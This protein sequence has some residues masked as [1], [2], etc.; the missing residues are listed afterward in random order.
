MRKFLLSLIFL[1]ISVSSQSQIVI[2]EFS[3]SNRNTVLDAFNQYEDWV[4][5]YNPGP[6]TINIS[7]YYLSDNPLDLMKWQIPTTAAINPAS[8]RMVFCSGRDLITGGNQ[9]HPDFKLTQTKGEWFI[10]SDA[11]GNI[12]D[13]VFLQLTQVGHSRGRTTDAAATWGIFTTPTPNASNAASTAYTN[14]ATKPSMSVAPGFYTT[15][16]NVVLS[17]PDPGV[18]IRYTIDGSTPIATSPAYTAAIPITIT[19]ALRARAFSSNPA[20]AVSFT[21][22]NTYL[23]NETTTFN[24]ISVT[25]PF[26]TTLF[27]FGSQPITCSFEYFDKNQNFILEY[28]GRAQRHGHDS[29]AYP[30]KGFKVYAKDEYGYENTMEHKFFGTSLRDEFDMVI[31]KAGASDSYPG[32]PTKSCHMRDMFAHTLAEKYNLEMDYRRYEPTIVFINGQYWGVYEIRERVDKDYFDYY[33]GVKEKNADN[34]RYWGGLMA[35]PGTAAGWTPLVNYIFNNSM[36]NPSNYQFVKDSLN[37]KSFAQ[38]FIFNQYLVNTD[39]LNWNTQWWRGRGTN[40]VKWRYALWDED[41]ILDLG[42]NYTGVGSTTYNNNPCDPISLFPGSTSV[43][44]TTMLD[45]L[46]KSP[47]FKVMYDQQWIDMLNGCFKCENILAHFDSMKNLLQPEMQRQ[48]TRWG[49]TM[50]DWQSNIA[51]MRNQISMRCA[52][53]GGKLDSCLDINPQELKLNVSPPGIGVI[54]LDGSLKSPYVWEKVIEGDSIYNLKAIVTGGMYW[55]FDHW[56]KQDA[57]NL[58]TPGP[59]TDSIQFNFKKKDSVIAF[60]KYFNYDSIDITFDVTPVGTGTILFNGV[61][62]PSYPTT[63]TMDR[64]NVYNIK[65]VPN[66]SYKFETWQKNNANTD[67]LPSLTDQIATLQYTDK[68]TVVA[69]FKF[70]PPPPPLPTLSNVVKPSVFIPN[71]FSPNG[72]GKN[73]VFTIRVGKDIIG[74]EMSIFDRWGKEVYHTNNVNAGWNGSYDDKSADIGVYQYIVKIRYRDNTNETFKGDVTLL[75]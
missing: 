68:E 50:A 51:Y 5:L 22:T 28:E 24:V 13:S 46:L 59:T 30:Q 23:I 31:L 62:V 19:T 73:D 52:V 43:P 53:I 63:F 8:R 37:V 58:F 26:S 54:T 49:G 20:I 10:L 32:G 75:R 15:T 74:M 2:N 36:S 64:R 33:Y 14:Y 3:C 66:Y 21:E 48:I 67:I 6:A 42:Q 61:L 41:N 45:S 40:P 17:S 47:E 71:V 18:T 27:S 1:G 39:W 25:G 11:S 56:E 70:L 55:S 7:G 4:E 65:A 57:T 12:V 16:Q 9:I 34:L 72:D 44:H 38:Y 60:F 69:E 29:W 35:G